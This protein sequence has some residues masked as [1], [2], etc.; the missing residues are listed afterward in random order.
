[1]VFQSYGN[2]FVDPE[3][4]KLLLERDKLASAYGWIERG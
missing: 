4:G 3:T 2:S 1:M